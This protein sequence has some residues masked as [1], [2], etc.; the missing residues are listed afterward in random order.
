ML[1]NNNIAE[2]TAPTYAAYDIKTFTR[3]LVSPKRKASGYFE[4]PEVGVNTSITG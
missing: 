4:I 1:V 3:E 2:I